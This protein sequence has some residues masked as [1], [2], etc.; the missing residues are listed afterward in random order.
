MQG[1]PVAEV[2]NKESKNKN[3]SEADN[4]NKKKNNNK[5][6]YEERR[7]KYGIGKGDFY[8]TIRFRIPNPTR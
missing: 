4:Q 6:L 5:L 3:E 7:Q 8:R 1:G 2:R